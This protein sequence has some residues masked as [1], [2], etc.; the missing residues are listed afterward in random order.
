MEKE[1]LA[2]ALRSRSSYA[3]IVEHIAP[4]AK[5]KK[6]DSYTPEFRILL[7]KIG[8]YYENDAEAQHVSQELMNELIDAEVPNDKHKEKF[9]NILAEAYGSTTSVP[10]IRALLIAAK[11]GEVGDRLAMKLVN[12]DDVTEELAE[13]NKLQNMTE[14]DKEEGEE[15]L[16]ADTLAA[17]LKGIVAGEAGMPLY[18]PALGAAI[19]PRGLLP[20]SHITVFGRPEV[21]KTGF[22][23]TNTARWGMAGYKVLYFINEDPAINIQLRILC[24][25]TGLQEEAVL[26]DIDAAIALAN[27]RGFGNITIK[28]LS[29]GSAAEVL[30]W[31]EEEEPDAI[32]I[33]QLR[34]MWAKADSRTNQL[35]QVAR[36]VR[37]IG[38]AKG[39]VVMDVTQAGESA[40]GKAILSMTDIDSSKTGI[41]AAADVL[42]G[43]GAT[44]EQEATGYRILT[45]CKNKVNGNHDSI[46]VRFIPQL[47][48]YTDV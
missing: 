47:S 44:K 11:K 1:L 20:G 24:C 15:L 36:D 6:Q 31:V 14:L 5:R 41:P 12:R 19:G 21:S 8:S 45:L 29:P 26:A 40:E 46:T 9:K 2:A 18:P 39:L 16:T 17:A 34:N 35:D 38:K 10:N 43:I 3:L 22:C 28:S 4:E 33:D 30:R 7:G 13:Y 25:I 23:I 48:R 37:D 42:I 32:I 27:T